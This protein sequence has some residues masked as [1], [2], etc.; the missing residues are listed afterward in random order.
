[1]VDEVDGVLGRFD[2]KRLG[3]G[4]TALGTVLVEATPAGILALSESQH[5]DAVLEDQPLVQL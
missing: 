2:G 1:M 5:V 3:D 4:V